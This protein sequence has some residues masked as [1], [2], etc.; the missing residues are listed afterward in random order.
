MISTN[1]STSFVV[2]QSPQRV[3]D[4]IN[5]VRGWWSG[6]IEGPTDRLGAEFTYRYKDLH[7]T[8]Q[9]ITEFVPGKLVVWR[10]L[11]AYLSFVDD[12]DEWIGTEVPFEIG[13][14]DGKTELRFTHSGLVPEFECYGACS[15]AWGFYISTSLRKLITPARASPMRGSR[16]ECGIAVEC[17]GAACRHH[18][19][20]YGGESWIRARDC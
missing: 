12:K 17:G 10:V 5:H 20:C 6:E 3:F 9:R 1:F 11:E 14:R 7:Y 16:H 13:E 2:D 15:S 4:A 8:K 18:G 19:P